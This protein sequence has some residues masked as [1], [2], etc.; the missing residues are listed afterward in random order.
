MSPEAALS[1]RSRTLPLSLDRRRATRDR[2]ERKRWSKLIYEQ[3]HRELRG[4]RT[5]S[6][7]FLLDKF[8]KK[9]HLPSDNAET[10]SQQAC[11]LNSSNF[12]ESPKAIVNFDSRLVSPNIMEVLHVA[13]ILF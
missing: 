10:V 7:N 12:A 9:K 11:L 8:R 5:L 13:L 4:W 1:H 3:A 6:D 2:E